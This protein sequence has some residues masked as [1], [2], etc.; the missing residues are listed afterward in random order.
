MQAILEFDI[1]NEL[2]E[3]PP[4]MINTMFGYRYVLR[5]SG[6]FHSP[7]KPSFI[8]YDID[9]QKFIVGTYVRCGKKVGVHLDSEKCFAQPK[10]RLVWFDKNDAV[11]LNDEFDS[12]TTTDTDSSSCWHYFSE[13]QGAVSA[14]I[15][16]NTI[17]WVSSSYGPIADS[18]LHVVDVS[19]SFTGECSQLDSIDM[20]EVPIL[21]YPPGLE[22]LSVEQINDE[23]Y[24]WMVTEFGTRM[25]FVTSLK[26]ILP[27]R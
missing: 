23:R 4:D 24:M 19:S 9:N 1:A 25:V 8:S 12:N 27:A 18:H 13:M 17:V 5:Q 11:D 22:D 6:S 10:N 16:N 2:Y 3:I 7:T 15:H 20:N 14:R 21:R 26:D